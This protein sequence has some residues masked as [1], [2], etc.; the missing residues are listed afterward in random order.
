MIVTKDK[1]GVG[2]ILTCFGFYDKGR[3]AI[4]KGTE[5]DVHEMICLYA[6]HLRLGKG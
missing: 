1:G 4:G 2:G 6:C 3:V 5:R